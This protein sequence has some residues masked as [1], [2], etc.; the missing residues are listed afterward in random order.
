MK[1]WI[2]KWLGLPSKRE[3]DEVFEKEIKALTD[4]K[5]IKF[6]TAD[7]DR[8]V[9]IKIRNANMEGKFD[10]VIDRKLESFVAQAVTKEIKDYMSYADFIEGVVERINKAQLKDR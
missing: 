9:E 1:E 8:A 5:Y 3:L 10:Q 6:Y 2:R 7:I 4:A